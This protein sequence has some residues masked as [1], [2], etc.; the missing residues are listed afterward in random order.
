MRVDCS[1]SVNPDQ[2]QVIISIPCY[3]YLLLV[4]NCNLHMISLR[5]TFQWNTLSPVSWV[6]AGQHCE[7]NNKD[8]VNGL[9]ILSDNNYQPSSQKFRQIYYCVNQSISVTIS[10]IPTRKF[11]IK[12]VK[13]KWIKNLVSKSAHN[14]LTLVHML[15]LHGTLL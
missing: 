8:E 12:Y 13:K 3:S 5:S 15:N 10:E 7:Y 14:N 2:V 6:L 1:N 4:L 9:N 11:N